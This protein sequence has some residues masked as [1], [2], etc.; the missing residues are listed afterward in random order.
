[1]DRKDRLPRYIEK[2]LVYSISSIYV[3]V[4][5]FFVLMKLLPDFMPFNSIIFIIFFASSIFF[6]WKLR[7]IGKKSYKR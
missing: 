7:I 2:Y 6:W 4:F 1:M 3:G 5:L